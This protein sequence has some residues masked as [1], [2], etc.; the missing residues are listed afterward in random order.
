M[1]DANGVYVGQVRESDRE[2]YPPPLSNEITQRAQKLAVPPP[3]YL[4][5]FAIS[6]RFD[7]QIRASPPSPRRNREEETR[8]HTLRT[9]ISYRAAYC[10]RPLRAR[11]NFARREFCAATCV[12]ARIR[13]VQVER[14]ANERAGPMPGVGISWPKT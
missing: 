2:H 9:A 13:N 8:T 12:R 3:A 6:S 10:H 4:C 11:A 1:D 14:R 7:F 5:I